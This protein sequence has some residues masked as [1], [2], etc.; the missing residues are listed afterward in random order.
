MKL[1]QIK[2]QRRALYELL[3]RNRTNDYDDEVQFVAASQQT[4]QQ[5]Q[6]THPDRPN[7][8][9]HDSH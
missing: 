1:V 5:Q 7:K 8:H 9:N 4:A 6:T 3:P 2:Q